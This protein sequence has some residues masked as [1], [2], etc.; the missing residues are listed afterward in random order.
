MNLPQAFTCP[1]TL[2]RLTVVDWSSGLFLIA[3]HV[4]SEMTVTSAPVSILNRRRL[5]LTVRV[6]NQASL[7]VVQSTTPRNGPAGPSA[8]TSEAVACVGP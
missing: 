8:C 4:S 5:R 6:T 7:L 2:L 3:S 1:P